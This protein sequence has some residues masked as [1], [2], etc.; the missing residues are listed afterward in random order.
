MLQNLSTRTEMVTT[1]VTRHTTKK[2]IVHTTITVV[3]EAEVDIKVALLD[4][5]S[6]YSLFSFDAAESSSQAAEV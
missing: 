1:K 3:V 6:S 2:V 5:F 4:A